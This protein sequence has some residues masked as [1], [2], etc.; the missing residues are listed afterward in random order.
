M[1]LFRFRAPRVA[2]PCGRAVVQKEPLP[3]EARHAHAVLRNL[4]GGLE[5]RAAADAHCHKAKVHAGLHRAKAREVKK[6]GRVRLPRLEP[7]DGEVKVGV[8][9]S[10]LK[11]KRARGRCWG[12]RLGLG[13]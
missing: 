5:R 4:R 2:A 13:L 7:K 1:A 11:L 10:K 8:G 3:V 6:C 9:A 12:G